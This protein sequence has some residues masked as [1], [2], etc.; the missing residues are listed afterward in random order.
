MSQQSSG[1]GEAVKWGVIILGAYWLY[2]T[3][4]AA[5]GAAAASGSPAAAAGDGSSAP[6]AAAG[7]TTPAAAASVY[8]GPDLDA[9]YQALQRAVTAAWGSDPSLTCAVGLQ[10]LGVGPG[11]RTAGAATLPGESTDTALALRGGIAPRGSVQMGGG[12]CPPASITA[13]Y[14]VFNW[15]LMQA[16]PA[17]GRAPDSPDHTSQITLSAYWQWAAP[18]LQ[19]QIP[20]LAG[21]AGL[22]AIWGLGAWMGGRG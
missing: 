6:P 22:G 17:I 7:G 19:K 9:I 8:S 2:E 14:D 5:S 20:G 13:T 3:F 12:V 15:Y 16:A 21:I 1:V 18:A 11:A 4:F 10:G